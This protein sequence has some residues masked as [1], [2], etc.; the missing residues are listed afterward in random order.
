LKRAYGH[1]WLFVSGL[2]RG[3]E[4]RKARDEW[5][6]CAQLEKDLSHL[7]IMASYLARCSK[8]LKEKVGRL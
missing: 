8:D 2:G 3:P 6:L 1:E 7:E 4:H 5:G